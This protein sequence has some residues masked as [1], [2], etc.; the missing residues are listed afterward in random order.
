MNYVGSAAAATLGYIVGDV[1]GAVA[2]YKL[3]Y[4]YGARKSLPKIMQSRRPRRFQ[5]ITNRSV[6]MRPASAPRVRNYVPRYAGNKRQRVGRAPSIMASSRRSSIASAAPRRVFAQKKFSTARTTNVS[7][8][9]RKKVIK[10]LHKNHGYQKVYVA[11]RLRKKIQK[12]ISGTH[13]RGWLQYTYYGRPSVQGSNG[14]FAGRIGLNGSVTRTIDGVGGVF[15]SPT[16][17][18]D[19][20]SVLWNNKTPIAAP[21]Y[22]NPQNFPWSQTRINMLKQWATVKWRN[23]GQRTCIITMFAAVSKTTD[24]GNRGAYNDWTSALTEDNTAGVN[25]T[26]VS[27]GTLYAHPYMCKS[28]LNNWKIE[29]TKIYLKPGEEYV[30]T[31]EGPSKLYDFRKYWTGQTANPTQRGNVNLFFTMYYDLIGESGTFTNASRLSTGA[32]NNGYGC[33]YEVNEYYAVE[34]PEQA[35]IRWATAGAPESGTSTLPADSTTTFLG[36]KRDAYVIYNWGT[37]S[38]FPTT[39]NRI[40]IENPAQ[41]ETSTVP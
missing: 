11:P 27:T 14:Q 4:K 23:N 29:Q 19:V 8:G 22:N 17:A 10:G 30:Y 32:N 6:A 20:A 39:L 15:F 16:Q 38:V 7:T 1:P 33:M 13:P 36:N 9:V 26:N 40:D 18:N 2:G 12:V 28:L 25:V 5:R 35:G 37:T 21:S 24:V 41:G 31:V 34:I 3:Y